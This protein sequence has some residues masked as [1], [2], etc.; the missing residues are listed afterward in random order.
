MSSIG[1]KIT[2]IHPFGELAMLV[3][4]TVTI[5]LAQTSL[6]CAVILAVNESAALVLWLR[7]WL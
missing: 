3:S 4:N 1:H 6:R 2:H 7:R 5:S